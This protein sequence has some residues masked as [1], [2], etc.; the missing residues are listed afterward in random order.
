MKHPDQSLGEV[1]A[2]L[3]EGRD[4]E[5]FAVLERLVDETDDPVLKRELEEVIA[6]GRDSSRGFRHAWDRLLMAYVAGR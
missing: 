2:L 4:G 6:S 5:A 1:T 3:E